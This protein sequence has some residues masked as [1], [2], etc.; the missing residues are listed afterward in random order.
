MSAGGGAGRERAVSLV[1]HLDPQNGPFHVGQVQ[2]ATQAYANRPGVTHLIDFQRGVLVAQRAYSAVRCHAVGRG[3]D[4]RDNIRVTSRGGERSGLTRPYEG[5][6]Q[7]ELEARYPSGV[8]NY[9]RIAAAD[10]LQSVANATLVKE[11]GLQDLFLLSPNGD[12]YFTADVRT[13]AHNLG[14]RIAGSAAWNTEARGFVG[15]AGGIARADA[16]AFFIAGFVHPHGAALVR[17]LR[18]RLGPDVALM[19][20][21]YFSTVP[22]LLSRIGAAAHGMYLSVFGVANPD[23]PQRGRR[24]LEEFEASSARE[25]RSPSTAVYAA[26]ATEILLD[27]IAR[28]DGTRASLTRELSRTRSRMASSGASASISTAT[29]W[30]R[31]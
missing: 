17:D 20:T 22:D 6:R 15:L 13:A 26:Q 16:Q 7:G 31:R 2:L 24:L 21:D 30:R 25:Q 3:G 10:R 5:M 18:A 9:V 23:L 8:R 4:P 11:L 1:G 29:W 12:R 19:A 27:A 28:S 14:V